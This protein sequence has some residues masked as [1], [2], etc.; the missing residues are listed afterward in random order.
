[1]NKI[2]ENMKGRKIILVLI[3]AILFLEIYGVLLT[4]SPVVAADLT[5]SAGRDSTVMI[6][7]H[8]NDTI[9]I[10]GVTYTAS[11]TAAN[12]GMAWK[13]SSGKFYSI[14]QDLKPVPMSEAESEKYEPD[15]NN[16]VGTILGNIFGWILYYIAVAAGWIVSALVYAM[17]SV[18]SY[19]IN[20]HLP[21]I[22]SGWQAIRDICNNF[23]IVI[24]IAIAIGTII[25][26]PQWQIKAL[27][28]KL[29]IMAILINFSKMF[30]G[31]MIDVSQVLMLAFA[32]PLQS[33]TGGNIILAALGI[34][35]MYE[36]MDPNGTGGWTD[37][38]AKTLSN[39]TGIGYSN[40]ITALLYALIASL[41]A[42]AVMV[43]IIAILVYRIVA[44]L[45][46]T[47]LSPLP[48]ILTTFKQGEKYAG[49]WWS[50]MT[51]NLVVGPVM[52]FF[53][54][55][56]FTIMAFTG[57][58]TEGGDSSYIG[59]AIQEKQ[60]NKEN[61]G[62]VNL[63][64]QFAVLSKAMTT[65]GII[66]FGMVIG[67]LIASL[68]M[69]KS[70]GAAGA[71]WAGSS[72]SFLDKAR[73]GA[74]AMPWRATKSVGRGAKSAA[75]AIATGINDR[76]LIGEGLARTGFKIA[77]KV[78]FART[79]LSR[80]FARMTAN[81][82]SARTKRNEETM[83]NAEL[84]NK[85]AFR[86]MN[87]EELVSMAENGNIDQR[88]AV[89]RELMRQVIAN[90]DVDP[91]VEKRALAATKDLFAN[92]TTFK[93]GNSKLL[94]DLK[95]EF[96][97]RHQARALEVLS[98]K[99]L[100]KLI[101]A[102][103]F[104]PDKAARKISAGHPEW[105]DK[106]FS[107]M[108]TEEDQTEYANTYVG[109]DGKLAT[110][111]EYQK[112]DAK[113]QKT[114]KK[115]RKAD[116]NSYI[117]FQYANHDGDPKAIANSF[118]Q[119]QDE[120]IKDIIR[121]QI[122]IG[123]L[124]S[125]LTKDGK[126]DKDNAMTITK[127]LYNNRL[128]SLGELSREFGEP[129]NISE[130]DLQTM[131]EVATAVAPDIARLSHEGVAQEQELKKKQT[132]ATL[133]GN[134]DEA[135]K[136][137]EE[138][139]ALHEK[140]VA[141]QKDLIMNCASR[142]GGDMFNTLRGGKDE[143]KNLTHEALVGALTEMM[144]DLYAFEE[145]N[146]KLL[147]SA[148]NKADQEKNTGIEANYTPEEKAAVEKQKMLQSRAALTAEHVYQG[149]VKTD[150]Y[151]VMRKLEEGKGVKNASKRKTADL[152]PDEQKVRKSVRAKVNDTL[153]P[154]ISVQGMGD[155]AKGKVHGDILGSNSYNL[156][157]GYLEK[158]TPNQAQNFFDNIGNYDKRIRNPMED[159]LEKIYKI[160]NKE[161]VDVGKGQYVVDVAGLKK[162]FEDKYDVEIT[163]SALA[164]A[165]KIIENEKVQE[166][167]RTGSSKGKGRST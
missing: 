46:L 165:V 47:V 156:S 128:A 104:D 81:M 121:D 102:A 112:M 7:P 87:A 26:I 150:L 127:S 108:M 8:F 56:S 151:G 13:D 23:F 166:Y 69:G 105:L 146:E 78:P 61:K 70:T 21:A 14:G 31:I 57:A 52:L 67:M 91:E 45:F 94:G 17:L 5:Q 137:K 131:T 86:D 49:Q 118:A 63:P 95:D 50:Q 12:M 42:A 19:P 9:T 1:M 75:G 130:A 100:R 135:K 92:T 66:N 120:K 43:A 96:A 101:M 76:M 3:V 164:N 27:L 29:L 155:V 98:E 11:H 25:K 157:V 77:N 93:G 99:E 6:E 51:N 167:I 125:L 161:Q 41:V 97:S 62:A 89:T 90:P 160:Q 18:A 72:L 84:V 30:C 123:D 15:S 110:A 20:T 140:L 142:T 58:T 111:A 147:Q 115:G 82:K 4:A 109:E 103:K 141:Q 74:Q 113:T 136:L 79:L 34:P 154:I 107:A 138:A 68:V 53:L 117:K 145:A 116:I 38:G 37:S 2:F 48:F 148:K 80:P 132:E 24:L 162:Y 144:Q 10:N 88:M 33:I 55:V 54:W 149:K 158:W 124:K 129:G 60:T 119:F 16:D 44:L 122:N 153:R 126:I 59:N 106:L 64:A 114:F 65:E 71:S 83:R 85:K 134:T 152:T 40:I 143:E 36:L 73:K 163:D 159:L 32:S 22:S 133:S 139:D 35:N 28:P 39:T